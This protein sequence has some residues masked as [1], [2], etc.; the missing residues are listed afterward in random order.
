MGYHILDYDIG[1]VSE[2]G[3]CYK[4]VQENIQ[5]ILKRII[6]IELFII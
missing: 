6:E 3:L 5:C 1:L 4:M 2:F